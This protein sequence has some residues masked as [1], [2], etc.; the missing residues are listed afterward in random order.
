MYKYI[1]YLWRCDVPEQKQPD[2]SSAEGRTGALVAALPPLIFALGITAMFLIAVPLDMLVIGGPT[3]LVEAYATS[4]RFVYGGAVAAAG[5]LVLVVGS[6]VAAVR[7]LPDWGYTWVGAAAAALLTTLTA[8]ADE[9]EFLI[10]Q[11]ADT[12]ILVFFLI[13]G[14]AVLGTAVL[15]GWREGGLLS[16]GFSATLGLSLCS[17]LSA[18]PF[19]RADLTLLIGPLGLL[20]AALTFAFYRGAQAVRVTAL[21]SVGLLDAGLFL[22]AIRVWRPWHIAQGQP[23]PWQLLAVLMATLLVGPVWGS[24]AR[25]CAV[26]WVGGRLDSHVSSGRIC[27][28]REN[29]REEVTE[30]GD[31]RGLPTQSRRFWGVLVL[32]FVAVMILTMLKDWWLTT[33]E[34][35]VL[36]YILVPI[37]SILGGA[38]SMYG[39]AKIGKQAITFSTMLAISLGVNTLMQ[40]VENIT[41]IVYYR[42]WEYPGLLYIVV[43]IPLGFLL[44]MYGLVRWGKVKSWIAVILTVFDFAG[45]MIV[46][47]LLTD[48]IGLATPGS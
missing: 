38:L 39:V 48:V 41:K 21:V 42:V 36:F 33:E 29:G 32:V 43:V 44:L 26:P 12:A 31:D 34:P 11:A 37:L 19:N 9:S 35:N 6:L 40:V 2:Q 30:S 28:R 47:V 4:S 3:P 24:L 15:R 46:G 13:A 23:T 8:L 5:V 10:S 45:S 14:I 18:G 7:R 25:R 16:I 22:M 27:E 17:W 1:T 20:V